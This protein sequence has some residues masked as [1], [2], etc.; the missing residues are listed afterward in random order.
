MSRKLP[1]PTRKT[2][3]T[4]A[5][6]AY[7]LASLQEPSALKAT[8]LKHPCK[9]TH[10]WVSR[11]YTRRCSRCGTEEFLEGTAWKSYGVMP[12]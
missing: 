5:F 9:R 7:S 10:R 1:Y 4:G 2:I 8:T 11:K 6:A 3:A 12:P